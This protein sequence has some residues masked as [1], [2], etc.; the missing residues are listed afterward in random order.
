M[1]NYLLGAEV[2]YQT[3]EFVMPGGIH[4]IQEDL[5]PN[6]HKLRPVTNGFVV[7]NVTGIRINIVK[8]LDGKGYEITRRESIKYALD[9]VLMRIRMMSWA[10]YC[11]FRAISVHQ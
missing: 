2:C 7:Q 9:V 1:L 6:T 10:A 5:R 11:A 8:R 3:Y 4:A